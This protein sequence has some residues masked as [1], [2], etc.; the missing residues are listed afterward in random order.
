MKRYRTTE[1]RILR[2][3]RTDY[4]LPR[5][6]RAYRKKLKFTLRQFKTLASSS[7]PKCWALT[8]EL[9]ERAGVFVM[10][11]KPPSA[12]AHL[13]QYTNAICLDR[14]AKNVDQSSR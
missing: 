1:K 9:L 8:R 5:L 13:A 2:E 12:T 3:S 7:S 6:I 4:A 10:I 11:N 14:G